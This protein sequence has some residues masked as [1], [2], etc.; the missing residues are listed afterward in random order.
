MIFRY[1]LASSAQIPGSCRGGTKAT[2]GYEVEI[3]PISQ[4]IHLTKF[5][6]YFHF[7][8]SRFAER[9][10]LS[11]QMFRCTGSGIRFTMRIQ[12]ACSLRWYLIVDCFCG[13]LKNFRVAKSL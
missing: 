13:R 3:Q 5:C 4:P 12:T 7:Q 10:A 2:R 8:I 1:S 11:I 6:M 9:E